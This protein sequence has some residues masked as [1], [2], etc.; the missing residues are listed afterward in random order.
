MKEISVHELKQI[1]DEKPDTITIIDVREPSEY[2][3]FNLNGILVPLGKINE[4]FNIIPKNSDV[5]VHCAHGV[6][7]AKA[8]NFLSQHH[9]YENLIN[10]KG[11]I[12]EWIQNFGYTKP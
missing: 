1:L 4:N 10:L 7:S 12:A 9:G 3:Q 8:I 6:R 2:D 11:G 5:V